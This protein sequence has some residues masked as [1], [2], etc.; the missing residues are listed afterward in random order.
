M[1]N[2]LKISAIT[3]ILLFSFSVVRAD[4]D[5]MAPPTSQAESI[6]G[7]N[8]GNITTTDHS[9]SINNAHLIPI[10]PTGPKPFCIA[11]GTGVAGQSNGTY[12][13]INQEAQILN[14]PYVFSLTIP[15]LFPVTS[16]YFDILEVAPQTN[17]NVDPQCSPLFVYGYATTSQFGNPDINF[18]YLNNN[19][20]V[21]V[22]GNIYST[23]GQALMAA[24]IVL[25]IY[26]VAPGTTIT[27][28][29][30]MNATLVGSSGLTTG[31]TGV[32]NGNGYFQNTYNNITPGSSY[33]LFI[34][35]TDGVNIITPIYFE[36]PPVDPNDPNPNP[37]PGPNPGTTTSNGGLV[38]C[39]F[40]GGPECDFNMLIVLVNNVVDFLIF[41]IGF[42][43]VAI[44]VAWAGILLLTSGGN[45][46]AKD[47]AKTM[48]WH[49]VVGLILA[50]LCW[51]IIKLIL[52][53]LG[54]Q[55]PLL[56]IFGIN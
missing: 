30:P 22:S 39:G 53:A 24:Q 35:N 50:L 3:S 5:I 25:E 20:S 2:F 51:G 31:G 47:K 56:T 42:P 34:K 26:E 9:I 55:G 13:Y 4:G 11:W 8:W 18:T 41:T 44:V 40:V 19:T 28:N 52:V 16:Y 10:V 48:L 1:K 12:E 37:T 7:V 54:Y 46:G 15:N 38:P 32:V 49:V 43:V 14:P 27:E 23:N 33:Y 21:N 36:V 29:A 6:A 45:S 17:P